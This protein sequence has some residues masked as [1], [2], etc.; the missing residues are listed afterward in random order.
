M[1]RPAAIPRRLQTIF[2]GQHVPIGAQRKSAG[3]K[4]KNAFLA[5]LS[6]FFRFGCHLCHSRGEKRVTGLKMALNGKFQAVAHS[7]SSLG[8]IMRADDTR[9]N[10]AEVVGLASWGADGL[11][12]SEGIYKSAARSSRLGTGGIGGGCVS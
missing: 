1:T 6:A 8:R 9:A 10:A 11:N 5:V 4:H 7:R 2:R 3:K 12:T